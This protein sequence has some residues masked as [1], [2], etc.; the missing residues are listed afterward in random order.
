MAS[1][2]PPVVFESAVPP[3]PLPS[4]DLSAQSYGPNQPV[5]K[6]SA[7]QSDVPVNLGAPWGVETQQSEGRHGSP[8]AE[9]DGAHNPKAALAFPQQ[10]PLERAA[11]NGHHR[12]TAPLSGKPA[13]G[14][15]DELG[16]I[17]SAR[18]KQVRICLGCRCLCTHLCMFVQW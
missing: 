17:L 18:K 11:S 12:R 14:P 7:P 6:A 2:R 3:S 13:A 9:Q 5:R 1:P 16:S 4:E 15:E 10:E 8:W